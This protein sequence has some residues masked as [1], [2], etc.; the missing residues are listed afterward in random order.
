MRIKA[1]NSA[2]DTTSYQE[3]GGGLSRPLIELIPIPSDD[4]L[5]A[6]ARILGLAGAVQ[7]RLDR[8]A[9]ERRT[10]DAA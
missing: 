4:Q 5:R 10:G 6:V 9:R 2:P 3:T 7:Q 8:E 1:I